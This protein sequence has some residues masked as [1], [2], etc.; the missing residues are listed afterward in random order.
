MLDPQLAW[1]KGF[2]VDV[3]VMFDPQKCFPQLT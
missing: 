3:V 2:D 1:E